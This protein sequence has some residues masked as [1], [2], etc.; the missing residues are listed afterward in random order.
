MDTSRR[1][2]AGA[3]LARSHRIGG[4]TVVGPTHEQSAWRTRAEK[5][6]VTKIDGNRSK[7]RRF[8]PKFYTDHHKEVSEHTLRNHRPISTQTPENQIK[9]KNTNKI[10]QNENRRFLS[11]R[12]ELIQITW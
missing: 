6:P 10:P 7:T 12:V 5:Q 3:A 4:R 8:T 2:R 11:A 9:A 1:T